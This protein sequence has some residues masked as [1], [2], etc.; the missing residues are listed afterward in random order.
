[1]DDTTRREPFAVVALLDEAAGPAGPA[2]LTLARASA[3]AR[4]GRL[5]LADVLAV[6]EGESASALAT[7]VRA[8]REA[9]LALGP[10]TAADDS[11]APRGL[12][13]EAVVRV[14]TDRWAELLALC[15]QERADLLIVP[16]A[17]SDP[18]QAPTVLGTPLARVLDETPCDLALVYV[19]AA[20]PIAAPVRRPR[21]ILLPVRGGPYARLALALG[22]AVAGQAPAVEVTLLHVLRPDVPEAVRAAEEAPFE[23]F[24][25]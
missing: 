14:G 6:A 22:S 13:A 16:L 9:L 17:V 1:M 12:Q 10:G 4:D 5:V 23:R 7:P 15:R 2:V 21:R 18:A 20:A 24:L 8:R 19:S 11:A 25:A 3:A